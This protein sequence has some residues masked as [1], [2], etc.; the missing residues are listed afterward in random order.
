MIVFNERFSFERD[1]YGWK[2][3]EKR[4]GKDKDGKP[5]DSTKTTYHANLNQVCGAIIDKTIG[6]CESLEE[7]KSLLSDARHILT[8]LAEKK[9][10]LT[11]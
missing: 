11:N 4:E 7:I 1:T 6:D 9:A 5:K 2:L 8:K 3:H 10:D